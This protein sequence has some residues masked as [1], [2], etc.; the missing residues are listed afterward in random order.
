MPTSKEWED[1]KNSSKGREDD[2]K[3]KR[4]PNSF[5]SPGA[6]IEVRKD[7]RETTIGLDLVKSTGNF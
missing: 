5:L 6:K 1:E 3:S 4:W 7:Y 2:Q